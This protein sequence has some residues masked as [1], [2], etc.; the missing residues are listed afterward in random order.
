MNPVGNKHLITA[1]QPFAHSYDLDESMCAYMVNNFI[2]E[3]TE[4]ELQKR[5]AAN[6]KNISRASYNVVIDFKRAVLAGIKMAEA[7]YMPA[8]VYK[9]IRLLLTAVALLEDAPIPGEAEAYIVYMLYTRG[10]YDRD[11]E[12]KEF[13]RFVKAC[14]NDVN[15]QAL[16]PAAVEEGLALLCR[17]RVIWQLKKH[18]RL[19]G[20]ICGKAKIG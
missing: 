16:S 13:V 8:Y 1:L 9:Y 12:E 7:V 10:A 17:M 19:N 20:F 4:A 6:F 2:R 15:R 14:Y 18:Y 3:V 5:F 11:I